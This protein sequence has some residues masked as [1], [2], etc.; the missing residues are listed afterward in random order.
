M[1]TAPPTRG[2]IIVEYR[3]AP[4]FTDLAARTRNDYQ[5][6]FDY[7][8]KVDGTPLGSFNT[9]LVVRIR[10]KAAKKK[11]RRFGNYVQQVIL[12]LFAWAKER[13]YVKENPAV[14]IPKIKRG[15]SLPPANRLWTDQERHAALDNAPLTSWFLLLLACLQSFVK[16]TCWPSRELHIKTA[17]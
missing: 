5:Q 1:E 12:L 4:R 3:N 13:G 16:A 2:K 14:G 7:L 15:K 6:V 8:K 11:G 10:D 9:E 17:R